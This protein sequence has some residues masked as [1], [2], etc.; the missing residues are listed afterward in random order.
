MSALTAGI[1]VFLCLFSGALAGLYLTKL[2]PPDH[3]SA[4]SKEVVKLATAMIATMAALVV[5]LLVASSKSSL[6]T[7]E[8]ELTQMTARVILLDRT[9]AQ[10]GSETDDARKL[11]RQ[12]AMDR[13]HQIWPNED[14]GAVAV[15]EVGNSDG[16]ESLQ[17]ML[18]ALAPAND[19]Q[20]YLKAKALQ[21]SD[22]ISEAR[23][24]IFE[25][26]GSG[27]HWPFL[28]IVIFWLA[29]VFASFGLSA[30]RNATVVVA[31]F[32]SALSVAGAVFLIVEMDQPYGGL[33]QISSA[34]L[35]QAIAVLG[36]P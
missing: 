13:L 2:L 1:I 31:L 8:S 10:Y 23:W 12:T 25:Q 27:I 16:I 11:L 6:D 28:S 18:H 35:R 34:P 14:A 26:V 36:K 3:L 15:G 17:N 29:F 20:R 9:L 33:V 32:A 19:K 21:I 4:P 5:G 24:M 7:K 22:Q 30:P